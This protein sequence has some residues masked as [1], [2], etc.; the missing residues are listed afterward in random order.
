[1]VKSRV[2]T[3][4]RITP[5]SLPAAGGTPDDRE[6]AV[7]AAVLAAEADLVVLPEAHL[8]GYAHVRGDAGARAHALLRSLPPT[9]MGYLDGDGSWLALAVDGEV[10]T[11]RKR[12]P[13]PAESRVWRAGDRPGLARTRLGRI[14]MLVCADVLQLDAWEALRGEVDAVVVAAAWPDYRGVPFDSNPYRD[15]LLA[16]AASSLGVPVAFA[17]ASGPG[18]SGGAR[19]FQPGPP[20]PLRHEAGW[21]AFCRMYRRLSGR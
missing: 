18:F 20:E 6:A 17:N 5:L 13:S 15:R 21:G 7:R 9:A 19:V 3:P 10:H 4:L 2:L 14:G 1:M 12:F 8:P 16:R 11:Y